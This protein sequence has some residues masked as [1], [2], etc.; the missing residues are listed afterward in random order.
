MIFDLLYCTA[1]D[2]IR[3][4]LLV[5]PH[6]RMTARQALAHPWIRMY[7]HP[8]DPETPQTPNVDLLPH[9]RERFNARRMFR[10]AIDVVKAVNKLAHSPQ[11]SANHIGHGDANAQPQTGFD[12]SQYR[13]KS[14]D[15]GEN[16]D[17]MV[18]TRT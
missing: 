15:H 17:L 9:V 3:K 6:E 18:I 16:G 14:E 2:F 1:K 10:K 13:P 4:L 11:G 7:Q 8:N 12:P 5:N